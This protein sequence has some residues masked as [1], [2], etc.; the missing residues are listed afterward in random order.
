[1]PD[2][3]T[4]RLFGPDLT[5]ENVEVTDNATGG[6][7]AYSSGITLRNVTASR[8]GQIGMHAHQS[9][10]LTYDAVLVEGNNRERFNPAPSAAGLKVTGSR[11]VVVKDSVFRDNFA[12]GIWLDESVYNATITGNDSVRNSRHGIVFELSGKATIANNIVGDNVDTGVLI[13]DAADVKIWNN[14]I[15]G[16]LLPVRISDGK[17]VATD[18]STAGHDKRQKLPDPTVT[19]ITR[20]IEFKNNVVGAIRPGDNWCSL[21]C[22]RDEQKKVTGHQMNVTMNGNV[23]HRSAANAPTALIRWAGGTSGPIAYRTL[24][25][26]ARATGQDTAGAETISTEPVLRSGLLKPTVGAAGVAIP[27]TIATLTG[28]I[29]GAKTVGPQPR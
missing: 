16:S 6:V 12:T 22:V 5:V 28:L 13:L 25:D 24:A 3:G 27:S 2:M 15:W 10:N 29:P 14:S 17:R 7:T 26:F 18:L 19:W 23:Y 9:D 21:V 20:N 4:L 1:V 11:T 8:N